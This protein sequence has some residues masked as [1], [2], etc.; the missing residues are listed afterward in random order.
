VKRKRIRKAKAVASE[1]L[2][3]LLDLHPYLLGPEQ[4]L[5]VRLEVLFGG[6][7]RGTEE[8]VGRRTFLDA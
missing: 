1:N 8:G 5:G 7:G 4:R 2:Q 6:R 3:F